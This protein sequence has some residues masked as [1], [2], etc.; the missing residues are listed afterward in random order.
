[1][2][3][4]DATGV[5]VDS[6]NYGGLVDPWAGEGYQGVSGPGKF[7]CY[8]NAPGEVGGARPFA[9]CQRNRYQRGPLPRRRRHR[10]QLRGLRHFAF[11][12]TWRS[13]PP[14]ARPISRSSSVE[15]FNAGETDSH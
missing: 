4:R 11:H 3:L 15:G 7:G 13:L 12:H 10:Q 8:V 6:L 1:M 9:P 2:V 5:V 14:Q